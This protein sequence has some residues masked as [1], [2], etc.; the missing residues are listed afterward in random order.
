[1][2]RRISDITEHVA[3]RVRVTRMFLKLSLET[4]AD[5]LGI[6]VWLFSCKENGLINFTYQDFIDL[7]RVYKIS[8][9]V[10]FQDFL[11]SGD[12]LNPYECEESQPSFTDEGA[13]N[14]DVIR[15]YLSDGEKEISNLVSPAAAPD[16]RFL[17]VSDEQRRS[18]TGARRWA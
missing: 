15:K 9:H 1:M 18:L 8:W 10:F 2:A 12:R 14:S 16:R 7:E 17:A 3:M 5:L 13:E 6:P 4:A 11:E